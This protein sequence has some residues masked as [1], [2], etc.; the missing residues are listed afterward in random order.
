MGIEDLKEE[1]EGLYFRCLESTG[2]DIGKNATDR[3]E[4]WYRRKKDRGLRVKV[5]RDDKGRLGGMIH[6]LPIEE[7]AIIG[8][9]LLFILCIWVPPKKG[10]PS[11]IRGMG[12]GSALLEAAETDATS[13]GVGGIVCW[14][15]N[16]PAFMRASWFRKHGYKEADR[17]GIMSLLWKPFTD[18]VEAPRWNRPLRLPEPE[19]GKT[20]VDVF[21]TGWC[22]AGNLAFDRAKRAADDLGSDVVYREYYGDDPE[23]HRSWG[24][25]DALYIDGKEIR[26]GP[27]PPYAKLHRILTRSVKRSR[28]RPS[29][30]R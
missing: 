7:T 14:G 29:A 11:S 16:V 20:T 30:L 13:A 3:K 9:N 25:G 15:I 5:A 23:V 6:Y 19:N 22:T 24:I 1:D 18:T 4:R 21:C 12:V 10:R 28:A 17:E 27:P 26:T 2:T 8:E